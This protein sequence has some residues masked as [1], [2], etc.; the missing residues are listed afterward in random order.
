MWIN[1]YWVTGSRITGNKNAGRSANINVYSITN[2]SICWGIGGS[3]MEIWQGY[4]KDIIGILAKMLVGLLV[5]VLVEVL[6]RVLVE[7]LIE[8]FYKI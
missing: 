4:N 3:M 8:V 2:R 1:Q 5:Q 7:V 6:I